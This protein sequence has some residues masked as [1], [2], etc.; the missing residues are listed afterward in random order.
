VVARKSVQWRHPVSNGGTRV[1]RGLT[2][3]HRWLLL[4]TG[5]AEA[6]N[7][8]LLCEHQASL[9]STAVCYGTLSVR[10][11]IVPLTNG[12]CIKH[13]AAHGLLCG[14]AAG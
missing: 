6:S 5:A 3:A 12:S 1:C 4:S 9:H 2:R 14:L 7:R 10:L 13:W 11:T 8:Q